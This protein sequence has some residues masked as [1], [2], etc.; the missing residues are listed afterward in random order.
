MKK[1]DITK[2]EFSAFEDVRSSGLTNMWDI[3]AVIE[4]SDDI[5]NKEV[6]LLIMKEYDY[7]MLKY[8]NIREKES[9][10]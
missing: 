8:P 4:L 10:F 3:K 2:E 1:E 9:N 7:L 6:C 5:L